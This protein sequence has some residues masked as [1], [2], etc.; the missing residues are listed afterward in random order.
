MSMGYSTTIEEIL[1]SYLVSKHGYT[2]QKA[3]TEKYTTVLNLTH[4]DLFDFS[5]PIYDETQRARF[6]IMILKY[7]FQRDISAET[8]GQFKLWAD[9]LLN[10]IMPKYNTLYNALIENEIKPL[11]NDYE[12]ETI[13]RQNQTSNNTTSNGN[14]TSNVTTDGTTMSAGDNTNKYWDQP[15]TGE[16]VNDN[17]LTTQTND[18][19]STN[20]SSTGTSTSSAT[21]STTAKND[22][23]LNEDITRKKY[24]NIQK[25]MTDLYMQYAYKFETVDNM[26]IKEVA[27]LFNL[28]MD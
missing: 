27:V 9:D 4:N 18:T 16:A 21:D 14:T 26:V 17:Y 13:S 28:L 8:V 10:R 12:V 20:S 23:T 2:M 25:S 24:G 6:E 15:Q 19:T 7:Y 22:G 1:R 5:Y 3:L 11:Y